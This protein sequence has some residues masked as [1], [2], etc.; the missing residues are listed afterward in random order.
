MVV[1]AKWR[2]MSSTSGILSFPE[3]VGRGVSMA[4]AQDH[5]LRQRVSQVILGAKLCS[6]G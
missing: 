6:D 2:T 4:T 3:R 5:Q 1:E